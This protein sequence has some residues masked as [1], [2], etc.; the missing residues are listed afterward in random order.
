M[1]RRRW[2]DEREGEEEGEGERKP[3]LPI[4]KRRGRNE[5]GLNHL[6]EPPPAVPRGTP[7]QHQQQ[8]ML[9]TAL[10]LIRHGC[11]LYLHSMEDECGY[12]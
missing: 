2:A 4:E 8:R 6:F 7:K 10:A 5:G 3:L 11:G 12:E 1:R 9:T